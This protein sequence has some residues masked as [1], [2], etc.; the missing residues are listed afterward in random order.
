MVPMLTFGIPG[1]PIM[2]IM[3]GV[4]AIK[5]IQPGPQLMT[6]QVGLIGPMLAALLFS[7]LVLIPLPLWLIGPYFIKIGRRDALWSN[8]I[9]PFNGHVP[10][11]SV[12]PSSSIGTVVGAIH[13]GTSVRK[14]SRLNTLIPPQKEPVDV[15]DYRTGHYL[16]LGRDLRLGLRLLQPV[17]KRAVVI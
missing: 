13:F 3:R 4:L 9:Q 11:S 2:A 15:T 5:G 12:G 8:L 6:D 14:Q 10:I 16:W 1:A 17:T 7:A